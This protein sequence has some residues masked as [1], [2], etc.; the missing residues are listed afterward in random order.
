[1]R[2]YKIDIWSVQLTKDFYAVQGV[3]EGEA[4]KIFLRQSG[5][6][7]LLRGNTVMSA[8]SKN[9]SVIFS[10]RKL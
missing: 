1:M 9:S 5:D 3:S 10:R 4:W 7:Q 2:E 6:A 8:L